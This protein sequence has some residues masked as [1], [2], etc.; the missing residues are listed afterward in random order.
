MEGLGVLCG[1]RGSDWWWLVIGRGD[2]MMM[3]RWRHD[4]WE[5]VGDELGWVG[6]ENEVK[7]SEGSRVCEDMGVS[8]STRI[9]VG[10]W[11]LGGSTT[12]WECVWERRQCESEWVDLVVVRHHGSG[13]RHSLRTQVMWDHSVWWHK[14]EG[15]ESACG[16]TRCEMVSVRRQVMGVSTQRSEVRENAG[17][18][19]HGSTSDGSE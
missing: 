10:V 1:V 7:W 14:W 19:E 11:W 9:G 2:E 18:S 6:G 8:G 16:D 17:M 3:M 4:G 5:S 13:N 12:P 15:C